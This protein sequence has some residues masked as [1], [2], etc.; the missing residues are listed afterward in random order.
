MELTDDHRVTTVASFQ[1]RSGQ[2]RVEL[3]DILATT[4]EMLDAI[5]LASE[6]TRVAADRLGH[7][8]FDIVVLGQHTRGKTTF[9]NALLGKGL[10]PTAIVP[11]TNIATRVGYAPHP[12]ARVTFLDGRIQDIPLQ[13]LAL[14][15][16]EKGNPANAKGALLVE[17]GFP[18][19]TL[20]DGTMGTDT[21]GVA[22]IF[23]QTTRAALEY[24]PQADAAIFLVNADPPIGEAERAFLKE[25]RPYLAKLV[26][27]Q[28]K[29]DQVSQED[30]EEP[31]AFTHRVIEET[32]DEHGIVIYPLSARMALEAKPAGDP[33]KL[34]QSRFD[35]FEQDLHA[36]LQRGKG[37]ALLASSVSKAR[38]LL[39][40]LKSR[41]ELERQALEMDLTEVAAKAEA[42]DRPLDDV[43]RARFED[44]PS[45]E[46]RLAD[47]WRSSSMRAS[48]PSRPRI[49][50][51]CA[52]RWSSSRDNRIA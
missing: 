33:A 3:L 38:R 44:R 16:T 5:G 50:R 7:N 37:R 14:S 27:V 52:R 41:A 46:R 13:E 25:V 22:S 31:L 47:S 10:L 9:I 36:F 29:I 42:F 43:E 24:I 15:T 48:K 2:A 45:C 51:G 17:V 23:E 32:V 20:R 4:G 34:R 11:L 49:C 19:I 40:S 1:D 30:Q 8:R 26:F 12:S 18:A 35:R 28:H 21:P 6:A 39:A